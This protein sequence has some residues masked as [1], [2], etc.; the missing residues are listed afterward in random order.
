MSKLYN[1]KHILGIAH[2]YIT[3]NNTIITV[4]NIMGKTLAFGSTGIL[5]LKGAKRSTTYAG[6]SLGTLIGKK[7]ANLGVQFLQIKVK[8]FGNASK[9]VLKG[10][11]VSNLKIL[12]IQNVTPITHNGCRAKKVRRI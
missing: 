10:L 5:G 3:F 4:T 2:V 7:V 1:N 9:S 8:G 6:Q 12:A 11:L